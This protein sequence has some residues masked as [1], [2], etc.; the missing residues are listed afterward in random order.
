MLDV[1]AVE[2]EY[3][4]K[5]KSINLRASQIRKEITEKVQHFVGMLPEDLTVGR[6]TQKSRDYAQEILKKE[7]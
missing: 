7:N 1:A 2:A 5:F 3:L 6:W 4:E